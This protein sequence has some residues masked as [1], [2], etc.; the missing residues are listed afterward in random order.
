M[1]NGGNSA[2]LYTENGQYKQLPKNDR[3]AVYGD[4]IAAVALCREWYLG[5]SSKGTV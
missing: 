4:G 1:N 3:L 2:S 5:K